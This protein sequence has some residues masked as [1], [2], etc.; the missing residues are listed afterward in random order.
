MPSE[1]E[2]LARHFAAPAL[3]DVFG[4]RDSHGEF[5]N[6]VMTLP[7]GKPVVLKGVIVG[8]MEVSRI[9]DAK[10]NWVKRETLKI[11]IPIHS[12]DIEPRILNKAS[13]AIESLGESD[14]VPQQ[15]GSQIHEGFIDYNLERKPLASMDQKQDAAV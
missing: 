8:R 10:G 1:F 6:V 2:N 15:E 3:V 11:S 14:W 5:S 13:F 7:S 9:E 12:N 4:E